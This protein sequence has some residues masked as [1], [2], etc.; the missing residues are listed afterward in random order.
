[1]NRLCSYSRLLYSYLILG[2]VLLM[3]SD[4]DKVFL[5]SY[6]EGVGSLENHSHSCLQWHFKF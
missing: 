2:D 6:G 1:M 4:V 3:N 5:W